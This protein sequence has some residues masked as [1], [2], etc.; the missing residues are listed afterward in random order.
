M[1]ICDRVIDIFKALAQVPRQS[2][3]EEKVSAWLVERAQKHGFD[4]ERDDANN[5][6]IR[7]PATPGYEHA[8]TLIQQG[9][10]DMV[11]EKTPGSSHTFDT[12]PIDVIT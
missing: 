3:H 12:D 4:V 10:M 11:C 2:K 6:F 7:V 1:K 8:P 9:H 5:V